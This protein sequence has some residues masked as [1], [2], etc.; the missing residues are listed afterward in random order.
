MTEYDAVIVGAGP[1]GLAAAAHLTRS[2]RQVL[3]VEQADTIGGG[4]R[5][6]ALTLPGFAHD[7]CSAIHPLGIASP[8]FRDVELD[9]EWIH[10]EIPVAHPIG[11][12]RAAAAFGD[13]D[14]TAGN[15]GED[16]DR[17][18]DLIG[19][20]VADSGDVIADFLRP[21]IG[22]PRNPSTFARM[23]TRGAL[24]ASRLIEGFDTAEAR[25]L[26][27]GMAGHAVAPFGSKLTGG[28]ALL[29]AM[30][31]H[32]RGWPMARAGS[33]QI[34]Q[35]L[36]DVV[37]AGGGTIE[38]SN[39]VTDLADLPGAEAYLLDLMPDA[40]ARLAGDRLDERARRRGAKHRLGPAAFKVDWALD[41]PIPWQDP[42]S[43]GAGTVHL[44]GTYEEVRSS[45]DDVH[46]GSHPEQP[47]VLLAQQTPFDPTRAPP[48]KHTAWAY[49]H[50]PNGS[51]VDM[52]ERIEAQVERFAPG[53]RDL[54]I[55]RSTMSPAN[56]ESHNPNYRGGDI[57]GGGFGMKKVLG[58]QLRHPYRLGDGVFL[59]SSATPPG[60][61]VHGMCG[62]HAAESALK[63]ELA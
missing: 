41:G 19:P 9:V 21:L 44:G 17:Y 49:C 55:G 54:V 29:F 61:G 38:T 60:A 10:P 39:R 36:A 6:E 14:A 22:V 27:A 42:L 11:D 1:N 3:V 63:R 45:E 23:A 56:L 8:F 18:L 34:A 25:A 4:T 31:A 62:Y 26:L 33:F 53:F 40:A 59:C 12:G 48:G 30:T 15:L 58:A 7:V 16:R 5:T 51:T 50:V 43:A 20:L 2:G 24:P 57:T 28:V 46:G 35:A 52:T 13:L 32:S 37:V 47:F